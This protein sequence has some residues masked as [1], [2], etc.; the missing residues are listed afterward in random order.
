MRLFLILALLAVV[1]VS[2]A[3]SYT[4]E[5]ISVKAGKQAV[6]KR[7]KLKI[8]FISVV[9]DSRCPNGAQ[10]VWAGNAKIKVEISVPKGEKKTVEINTGTGPKG[11]QVG[12]Y[13]VT[14]DSLTPYP[15][16]NKPTDPKKYSA[17]FS[18]VRLQR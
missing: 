12:G 5:T 9:E 2:S 10:C 7:S 11:D 13:A 15:N 6:A 17:K 3:Y 8:K 4:P 1:M 16:A 14:L 18:I